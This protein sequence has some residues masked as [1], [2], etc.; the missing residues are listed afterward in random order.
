VDLPIVGMGGVATGAD[1][2]DLVAVGANSVALGTILFSD[3]GAPVRIR[4]ELEA[5]AAALGFV[6][7]EDAKGVGIETSDLQEFLTA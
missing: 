4:A 1:A 6:Q 2:L 3:P 7:P 5:G